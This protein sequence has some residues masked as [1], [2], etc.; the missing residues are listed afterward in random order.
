MAGKVGW[1]RVPDGRFVR[2]RHAAS[3]V[4]RLR[5][6]FSPAMP[7]TS[8]RSA[9]KRAMTSAMWCSTPLH[10]LQT[11][12]NVLRRTM[13]RT[14]PLCL[15]SICRRLRERGLLSSAALVAVTLVRLANRSSFRRNGSKVRLQCRQCIVRPVTDIR[16]G[17]PR[18]DIMLRR[19]DMAVTDRRRRRDS[20]I[21]R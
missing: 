13:N 10:Q 21:K 1:C 20:H 11:A 17:N 4:C 5:T 15:S 7:S 18:I 14:N 2:R 19:V 8:P 6:R 3:S 12:R 9:T 16:N